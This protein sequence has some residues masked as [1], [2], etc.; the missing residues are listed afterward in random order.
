MTSLAICLVVRDEARVL[1]RCLQ[2]LAGLY[3]EICV[4]DTGSVDETLDIARAFGAS[5]AVDT[6]CND[7]QGRI[8]DFSVARNAAMKLVRAEWF[9]QIDADEILDAGHDILKAAIASDANDAV[10]VRMRSQGS[11]WMYP[12]LLRRHT[13]VEYRSPVHEYAVRTGTFRMEPGI[14]IVNLPNKDG[15]ETGSARN[16]RICAW[17]LEADPANAWLWYRLATE[18]SRLREHAMA[19]AAYEQALSTGN[20]A[21]SRYNALCGMAT[22]LA[23]VGRSQDGFETARSA[24]REVPDRAE[25]MCLLGDMMR[26]SNEFA[27]ARSWYELAAGLGAPPAGE[28]SMTWLD[29]YGPYPRARLKEIEELPG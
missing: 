24:V 29:A 14:T 26:R 20:L 16:I 11:Q 19:L 28:L 22:A 15:K 1:A 10:L 17:A 7:E 25:A 4:L 9:L 6:S 13:C 2:S 3:D 21:H 12:R 5:V 18:Y 23:G 8:R 27:R